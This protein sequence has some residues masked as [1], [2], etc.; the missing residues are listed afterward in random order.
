MSSFYNRDAMSDLMSQIATLALDSATGHGS[1]P[2]STATNYGGAIENVGN[3]LQQGAGKSNVGMQYIAPSYTSSSYTPAASTST[4]NDFFAN[5]YNLLNQPSTDPNAAMAAFQNSPFT[6]GLNPDVVMANYNL[7]NAGVIDRGTNILPS[8]RAG[9]DY[10]T[11]ATTGGIGG[12]TTSTSTASPGLIN[13]TGQSGTG[14][15]NVG[16]LGSFD[17]LGGTITTTGSTGTD[18]DLLTS[19]LTGGGGTPTEIVTTGTKGTDDELKTSLLTGDLGTP[20]EIVTTGTK[21]TDDELKTSLLTPDA[22]TPTEIVTTGTKTTDDDL[23][24]NLLTGDAGAPTEIVT[25]GTKTTDD[26]KFKTGVIDLISAVTGVD[27]GDVIEI[28]TK[29]KDPKKLVIDT[30]GSLGLGDIDIGDFGGDFTFDPSSFAPY[31]D[32]RVGDFSGVNDTTT[33]GTSGAYDINNLGAIRSVVPGTYDPNRR[34]GSGGQRYFSDVR[35]APQEGVAGAQAAANAQAMMLAYQNAMNPAYQVRPG[36]TVDRATSMAQRAAGLAGLVPTTLTGAIP[37]AR[38]TTTGTA[39]TGGTGTATTGGT[40]TATT[41]GT[42]TT[43]GTTSGTTGE[44]FPEIIG[45]GV[46]SNTV[47]DG[48]GE[49]VGGT[50]G[51]TTGGTGITTP[52]ADT[53]TEYNNFVQQ[54]SGRQLNAEDAAA[55]AN[56]GYSLNRLAETFKADPENLRSFISQQ[57]GGTAT[58]DDG[59]TGRAGMANLLEELGGTKNSDGTVTDNF[60]TTFSWQDGSFKP[61]SELDAFARNFAGKTLSREDL[62]SIGASG[63]DTT[64]LASALKV[65]PDKLSGAVTSA[66]QLQNLASG[67][68]GTIDPNY[69]KALVDS[70]FSADTIAGALNIPGFT[71]DLLEEVVNAQLNKQTTTT[72]TAGAGTDIVDA[73]TGTADTTTAGAGTDIVDAL[74]GTADTADT[75]AS[76]LELFAQN[77]AGKTLTSE[78]LVALNNLSGEGYTAQ[79]VIDT[80][81]L[82]DA[83]G[84]PIS[85]TQLNS[86]LDRAVGTAKLNTIAAD[87]DGLDENQVRDIAGLITSNT[88]GIGEVA[89]TFGVGGM[90]VVAEL[91]NAGYETGEQL[92][93]RLG[94]FNEGLTEV[95]LVANLLNTN[96]TDVNTVAKKYNTTPETVQAE[97]DKVNEQNTL[98]YLTGLSD[99]EVGALIN[100]NKLSTGQ[101]VKIYQDRYPGLTEADVE[102]ALKAQGYAQGGNVSGYYLG[103]TTDGMADQIP[104]TIN[105]MQPAALSDGEFVIPADV[106]SHLGNGN[107]DAGAK[108]LYSMM[109]RIRRDRTGTTKQGKEID[110]NKYLA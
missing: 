106:V 43:G 37:A 83:D 60:G 92:T 7:R 9:T 16:G 93:D 84:N 73:L 72:D 86:T 77:N 56:S 80:L 59:T 45:G 103:G 23:V 1:G 79:E 31:V 26:T 10:A 105:D 32:P 107:S 25:T 94:A 3:V 15:V 8:S 33:A 67:F 66:T 4:D 40:G 29:A 91:F 70:G 35:Y 36:A 110:P 87:T 49:I 63:Y 90:D 41:G 57:T 34:A 82:K 95:D 88:L 51:G 61:I 62:A 76:S 97:L 68:T 108:E 38:T 44:N 48:F 98:D 39:T 46:V 47:G 53:D 81:G 14:G 50:T 104:A 27:L 64:A 71:G 5:L 30:L 17:N 101:A 12:L 75:T 99:E 11:G 96:K 89:D 21:G 54:F 55:L 85:E 42:G 22:G 20:T 24:T 69:A 2:G 100:D 19:L 102:A 28:V 109:D 65:D 6:T 52:A 18:D 78:D 13:V 74:T 58:L